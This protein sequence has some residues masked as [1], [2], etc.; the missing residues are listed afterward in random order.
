MGV[1][2]TIDIEHLIADGDNPR[3]EA[4]STEE[5]ALF[6]I[7]VDQSLASGNK[8]L[9]L[10]RD[11]AAHG[12]NASELLI[13]S[14]IEGTD[15][16]RVREGNRRVTA[17]KLSLHSDQV[18]EGFSALAPHFKEL[19]ESMRQHR[20]IECYVCDDEEEI[21][22]LLVL[23]HGGE[24]GGI[25]TVKW[26]SVQTTRFSDGGNQQT[27]R[28]LSLIEH[29]KEDYGQ[30]ELWRAA[31]V[32]PAT[33]LGRLISTPEVRQALNIS[34]DGNDARY[35]GGHDNLLL[36]VLGQVKSGGVGPIYNK[37]A[38]VQL[39]EEAAQRVEPE[40][41][42]QGRLPLDDTEEVP[43]A[44]SA[45]N[46]AQTSNGQDTNLASFPSDVYGTDDDRWANEGMGQD[47]GDAVATLG[48]VGSV[49]PPD[50]PSQQRD[51]EEAVGRDTG[52][53]P[54]RRKPVSR[55][56]VK[57]MFGCVLRPKGVRS[58]DLY[59]A[60]DWMDQQYLSSPNE[61]EYLLPILG[62]SLRLLIETVAREYYE[63][64]DQD[65][66]QKPFTTFMKG[67]AKPAIKERIDSSGQ[68]Y[69]A[70]ASEWING[71]I[72]FEGL[73]HMWAHGAIPVDRASLVMQA[74]LVALIIQE[75]WSDG[76]GRQ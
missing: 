26:N 1:R 74:E 7:L 19:S 72:S 23:R 76:G 13:V 70:L 15:D 4:V 27:A 62:F 11:I 5:D 18:P 32:I 47:T 22:R 73:L 20:H 52:A 24:N 39:V 49:I 33:N 21:R 46:D 50:D 35:L 28:A 3:F 37:E 31:A 54:I 14:P 48:G 60:I 8:I 9:N 45:S 68:K 44:T 66:G 71:D 38:R 53:S 58:N 57:G 40:G 34:S 43:N 29:L 59:R 36:D 25:G 55:N 17:I 61:Q 63:S 41:P 10:A 6:S 75:V 30:G 51:I 12:L 42:K 2:K 64:K 69:M 65:P 67:V 16:Y 56:A